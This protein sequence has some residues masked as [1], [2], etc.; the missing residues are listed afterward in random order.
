MSSDTDS[1]DQTE[2]RIVCPYCDYET[3]MHS[4]RLPTRPAAATCPR[5]SSR[6]MFR[7]AAGEQQDE[8]SDRQNR[9]KLKYRSDYGLISDEFFSF[10]LNIA[11][12]HKNSLKIAAALFFGYGTMYFVVTSAY[13][14]H[15]MPGQWPVGKFS[16]YLPTICS[17]LLF[18]PVIVLHSWKFITPAEGRIL[19][20]LFRYS[21]TFI[22]VTVS[23][24]VF[25]HIT[26]YFFRGSD[27][28]LALM[29]PVVLS[30]LVPSLLHVTI[31]SL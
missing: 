4:D 3:P 31:D 16:D 23:Y 17:Y 30:S 18:F 13:Y 6:F 12:K 20:Q 7:P 10:Y 28:P 25:L 1:M 14:L 24:L 27:I 26:S 2:R 9:K 21:S 5:C 29:I 22:L 11:R 8:T 15:D 19:D